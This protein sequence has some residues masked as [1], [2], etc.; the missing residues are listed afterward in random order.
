MIIITPNKVEV[1][2]ELLR[3]NVF[4]ELLSHL[5]QQRKVYSKSKRQTSFRVHVFRPMT[6]SKV[7]ENSSNATG[8]NKHGISFN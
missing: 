7:F 5:F 8:S 3:A 4:I 6:I 1:I 2:Q